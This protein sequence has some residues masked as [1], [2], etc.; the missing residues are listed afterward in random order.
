MAKALPR[1]GEARANRLL[2]HPEPFGGLAGGE[3]FQNTQTERLCEQRRQERR[4]FD[5]LFQRPPRVQIRFALGARSRNA[6][7]VSLRRQARLPCPR[8]H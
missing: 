8:L 5:H 1:A 6:T 4:L 2:T 3:P 7:Q